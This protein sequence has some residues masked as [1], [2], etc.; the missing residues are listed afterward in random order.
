M[1]WHN[2]FVFLGTAELPSELPVYRHVLELQIPTRE[3]YPLQQG[4]TYSVLVPLVTGL[5]PILVGAIRWRPA[6]RNS[7]LSIC[8]IEEMDRI[9]RDAAPESETELIGLKAR[10][11]RRREILLELAARMNIAEDSVKQASGISSSRLR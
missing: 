6:G 7:F 10:E 11:I 1:R 9:F 4:S 5:P 2:R 3:P 8:A